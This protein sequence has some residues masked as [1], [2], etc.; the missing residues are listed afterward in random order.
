MLTLTN[1]LT[2]KETSLNNISNFVVRNSE[3]K[4]GIPKYLDWLL[5]QPYTKRL[6]RYESI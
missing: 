5:E 3:L 2:K 4:N 6:P 1:E